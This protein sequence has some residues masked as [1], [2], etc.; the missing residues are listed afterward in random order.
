[1]S[2]FVKLMVRNNKE[3]ITALVGNSFMNDEVKKLLMFPE[4]KLSFWYDEIKEKMNSCNKSAISKGWYDERS[5]LLKAPLDYGMIVIDLNSKSIFSH[6]GFCSVKW[7]RPY[8]LFEMIEKEGQQI[9]PLFNDALKNKIIDKMNTYSSEKN[10]DKYSLDLS[11]FNGVDLYNLIIGIRYFKIK[12][13]VKNDDEKDSVIND[14]HNYFIKR[15]INIDI[16]MLDLFDSYLVINNIFKVKEYNDWIDFSVMRSEL[17][18][19]GFIFNGEELKIWN[20]IR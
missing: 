13:H 15:K 2:G 3:I 9:I 16:E 14:M 4:N 19:E 7:I 10:K 18:N 6:Q 1:M 12:Q 11:D 20:K 5:I 17:E 8:E